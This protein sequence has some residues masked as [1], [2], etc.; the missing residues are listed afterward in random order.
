MNLT[1]TIP[2]PPSSNNLFANSRNGG[3][4]ISPKYKAWREEAGWAIRKAQASWDQAQWT[5][6]KSLFAGGGHTLRISIPEDARGDASNR[7]KAA[8]D[9]LVSLRITADDSKAQGVQVE[10]DGSV[11]KGWCVVRVFPSQMREAVN[12]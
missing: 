4:F 12:A 10:R 5:M 6:A 11:P 7:I 3:R 8:E 9:L 1:F 2:L